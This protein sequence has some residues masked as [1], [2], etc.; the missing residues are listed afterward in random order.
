MSL[1]MKRI[2]RRLITAVLSAA[3]LATS[4]L[5]MTEFKAGA[6]TIDS[7]NEIVTKRK[8]KGY[9]QL[10]QAGPYTSVSKGALQGAFCKI[11]RCTV[12]L[13]RKRH[14]RQSAH[15]ALQDR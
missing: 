9:R 11:Q 1:S 7:G 10:Q 3:I 12:P 15:K 5:P 8:E 6:D 13:V 2:G 4:L 14:F